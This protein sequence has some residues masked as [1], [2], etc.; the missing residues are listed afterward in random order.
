MEKNRLEVLLEIFFQSFET[1]VTTKGF[2]KTQG[3][4]NFRRKVTHL[5]SPDY[6]TPIYF[7]D[8]FSTEL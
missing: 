7:S 6:I 2:S 5:F 1:D 8:T 3:E 4:A